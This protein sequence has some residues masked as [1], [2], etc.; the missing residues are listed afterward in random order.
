MSGSSFAKKITNM[1]SKLGKKLGFEFNIYRSVNYLTPISGENYL[2]T[3][4]VSY[5]ID[6]SFTKPQTYD[7]SL[8]NI[9]ADFEVKPGDVLVNADKTLVVVG[10]ELFSPVQALS[11]NVFIDI[12]RP[13]YSATSGSFAPSRQEI[14]IEVPAV[15]I[16]T[17]SSSDNGPASVFP[18]KQA[19]KSAVLE[20]DVWC[21][22][23]ENSL[24]PNDILISENIEGTIKSIQ[25][26]ELGYK[27]HIV[28]S[29]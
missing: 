17:S 16:A 28:S 21:W 29:K 25:Y 2:A 3:K 7:F 14:Y 27:L 20:W 13:T 8:W 10:K 26:T 9:Y 6:A 18:T 22:L 24:K 12:F 11:T 1:N 5:T 15:I 23:P 4:Y 19:P